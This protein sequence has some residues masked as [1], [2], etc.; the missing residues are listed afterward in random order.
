MTISWR[1]WREASRELAKVDAAVLKA[2]LM[3]LIAGST[4]D[5]GPLVETDAG[6][7]GPGDR[8]AG[9]SHTPGLDQYTINLTEAPEGGNR[10]RD[11]SRGRGA[12][13]WSIS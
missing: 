12:A 10:P 13:R 6:E 2:N 4:E 8:S 9:V 11:R 5:E 7:S 1:D 3:K